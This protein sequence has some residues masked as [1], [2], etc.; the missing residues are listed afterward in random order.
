MAMHTKLVIQFRENGARLLV[1]YELALTSP[2]QRGH[3]RPGTDSGKSLDSLVD[4][5][6]LTELTGFPF[7][8]VRTLVV[9][10]LRIPRSHNMGSSAKATLCY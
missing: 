7:H 3:L 5:K 9:I 2:F 6:I 10:T 8:S 1:S 4:F